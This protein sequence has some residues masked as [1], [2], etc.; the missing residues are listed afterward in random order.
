VGY[1]EVFMT[2]RTGLTAVFCDD[3]TIGDVMKFY[4]TT[5][6]IKPTGV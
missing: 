5:E 1:Y 3:A 2:N 6:A 4:K